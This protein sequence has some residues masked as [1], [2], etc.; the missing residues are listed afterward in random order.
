MS[1]AKHWL[2]GG[3]SKVAQVEPG[4]GAA[5]DAA[6]MDADGSGGH[7]MD[8]AEHAPGQQSDHLPRPTRQQP[9]GPPQSFGDAWKQMH[10]GQSIVDLEHQP[11]G[12]PI[13][14]A[15]AG[16]GVEA[17]GG[18]PIPASLLLAH[19]QHNGARQHSCRAETWD[20]HRTRAEGLATFARQH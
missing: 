13:T 16:A 2:G 14:G 7:G 18:L 5:E 6:Q 17:H 20:V 1:L 3:K 10:P 4:G 19:A 11:H 8:G 12:G 15:G 9:A